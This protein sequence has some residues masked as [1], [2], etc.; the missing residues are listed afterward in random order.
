MEV[1]GS[2]PPSP[3]KFKERLR[4]ELAAP[5]HR[6]DLLI[7]GCLGDSSAENCLK[8]LANQAVPAI[9]FASRGDGLASLAVG[10]YRGFC[11]WTEDLSIASPKR[12]RRNDEISAQEVRL[13]DS[14]RDQRGV[15]S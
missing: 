14:A 12:V 1:G 5:S 3:T 2:K 4:H 11:L 6:R 15:M 13:I 7:G 8:F 9:K 10:P